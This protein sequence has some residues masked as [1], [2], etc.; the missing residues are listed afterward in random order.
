M[1]N[2]LSQLWNQYSSPTTSYLTVRHSSGVEIKIEGFSPGD[3]DGGCMATGR[4]GGL[5]GSDQY[6]KYWYHIPLGLSDE[7]TFVNAY[8][9]KFYVREIKSLNNVYRG[10]NERN[11]SYQIINS[12]GDRV[13]V[14]ADNYEKVSEPNVY[15]NARSF[16]VFLNG[17]LIATVVSGIMSLFNPNWTTSFYTF[18]ITLIFGF[19]T[20]FIFGNES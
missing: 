6:G 10:I 19:L 15:N 17:L 12:S 11:N 8:E 9:L 18:G 7:W 5:Y 2:K 20:H 16:K 3:D 1:Y 4:D 13:W 14:G